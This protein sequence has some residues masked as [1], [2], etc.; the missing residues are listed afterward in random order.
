MQ[1]LRP[2][3]LVFAVL[4]LDAAV[5]H[6]AQQVGVRAVLGGR[7]PRVGTYNALLSLGDRV[8]LEIIA[9]DP[10]QPHPEEP[11]SF[12][13][14]TLTADR[15]VTW[16]A[17]EGDLEARLAY[18]RDRGYDPGVL[19][20]GGRVQPD[21]IALAW[22]STKR[23]ESLTGKIALGDGLAPFLIDWQE[24][25]HPSVTTPQGCRLLS[26]RGEHP[27]PDRVGKL[28]QALG[29]DLPITAGQKPALIA[30][31]TGPAGEIELR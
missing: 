3:H 7:H 11:R 23:P 1:T 26:L 24:T 2:D 22:R 31:I 10:E 21:G 14:D 16:A 25:P 4:D 20:Q 15:L 19:V 30:V 9:A 12:S 28:L 18:A 8:Y 5:D 29:S 13:L 17:G 6:I 27:E